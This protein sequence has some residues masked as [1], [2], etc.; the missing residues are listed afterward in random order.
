MV[1]SNVKI[2][3]HNKSFISS[4]YLISDTP[5]QLVQRKIKHVFRQMIDIFLA[6][7]EYVIKTCTGYPI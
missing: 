2:L 3:I 7:S 1:Y 6:W 4:G 5:S